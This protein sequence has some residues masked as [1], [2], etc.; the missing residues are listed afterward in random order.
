VIGYNAYSSTNAV[1]P[2]T[3][4]T[5]APVV[6]TS[7]TDTTVQAGLTYYFVVTSVDSNNVESVHS[8]QVSATI[9]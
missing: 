3:K 4:L 7:D 2:Y 1:G 6:A 8:A 5:S 9:P